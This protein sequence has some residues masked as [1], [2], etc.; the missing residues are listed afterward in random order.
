MNEIPLTVAT[1]HS[2]KLAAVFSLANRE[3]NGG[4]FSRHFLD[5]PGILSHEIYQRLTSSLVRFYS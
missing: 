3:V 4:Y 5:T 2:G 1:L